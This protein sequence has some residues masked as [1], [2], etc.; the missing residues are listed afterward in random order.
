MRRFAS[1]NNHLS[2]ITYHLSRSGL[3]SRPRSLVS[4]RR[5]DPVELS[6]QG[7]PFEEAAA[8]HH[9]GLEL[10]PGVI[11]DFLRRQLDLGLSRS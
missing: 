4:V 8:A 2:R 5:I 10:V 6:Q 9:A 11:H 3:V 7:R 1:R